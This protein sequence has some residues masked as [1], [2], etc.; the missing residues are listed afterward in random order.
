MSKLSEKGYLCSSLYD[1]KPANLDSKDGEAHEEESGDRKG[2]KFYIF[3]GLEKQLLKIVKNPVFCFN[4][5][6]G[7]E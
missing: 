3:T 1:T 7:F 2:K 5:V 4:T 6:I